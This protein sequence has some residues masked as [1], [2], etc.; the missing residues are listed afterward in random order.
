MCL[1]C[2]V[3]WAV[4][5]EPYVVTRSD[6]HRY[7]TR[8]LGVGWNKVSHTMKMDTLGYVWWT[9]IYT[10]KEWN[11]CVYI[12]YICVHLFYTHAQTQVHRHKCT[13]PYPHTCMHA[14]SMYVYSR[15]NYV[16]IHTH[17]YTQTLREGD[18][19]LLHLTIWP[20]MCF[21]FRYICTHSCSQY[22]H[23]SPSTCSM[24]PCLSLLLASGV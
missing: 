14:Y 13:H 9:C 7:D 23:D 17:V 5:Y 10:R 22:V 4:K 8:F 21:S 11:I 12:I 24:H 18:I 1:C 6:V 20:V 3:E 2:K 15:H 16:Y 19:L